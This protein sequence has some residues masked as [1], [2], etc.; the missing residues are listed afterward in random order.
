M[1]NGTVLVSKNDSI[2]YK[3]SFG[4]ANE[5]TKEKITPESVFY[6][7]S[8]SKQFTAMGIMILKEK[9]KLSFDSKIKDFLPNYPEYLNNIKIRQLLNHTSGV[10]DTEYYKLINP[11]NE[12]VLEI[13]MKQDSLELENGSTFR[14]S[15]SGYVLLALIIEKVSEK[16]IDQFFNQE[17]FKPLEMKNTTATKAFVQNVSKKVEG[18]NLLGENVGY[19]S[20]VIGPGGIYS[21]LNDL[22]KWNKALNT[23]KLVSKETLNKAFTNGK[24]LKSPISIQMSGQ[25]YGYGFGW[26]LTSKGKT[27]YVQHDGTVESYRSLIKKNLTDGY[28]YIFLT[29]NGAKI[30]MNELTKSVDDILEKSK[31]QKPRIPI[32]N[33]ILT[34]LMTKGTADLIN[35]IKNKITNN[36]IDY[37]IEENNILRLAYNLLRK[38]KVDIAIEIF[39]LNVEL[40][41]N[42]YN[43]FD[44]LAEG[45][46]S[47]EQFELSKENYKKSIELNPNNNNAKIMIERIEKMVAEK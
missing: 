30:A 7:A 29:N 16:P 27:K 26:M 9:G 24:L 3:K 36:E 15:N 35:N 12:D 23:D 14:Y 17:I 31:Y 42:S 25:E 46:F 40:Y 38:N 13:L 32:A 22:E 2:I 33:V 5:E 8:V 11:S 43:A 4:Y 21:T 20:S 37:S 19:K 39:K 1:F 41:P 18:Y 6:I 44:S 34:H 10:S 45:Y 47:N 28:D